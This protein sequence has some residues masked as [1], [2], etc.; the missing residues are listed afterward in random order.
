M[1]KIV[2]YVFMLAMAATMVAGVGCAAMSDYLTPATLDPQAVD[3]VVEAGVADANDYAGYANLYKARM[4]EI[5]MKGAHEW[6]VLYY[7]QLLDKENLSFGILNGVVERNRLEATALEK[8]IFDPTT[9]LLAA[10]L[11]LFGLAGGGVLGLM[12]TKPGDWKPADVEDALTDLTVQIGDKE[13]QFIETVKGIQAF[14]DD[15]GRE[16]GDSDLT[17][18][19]AVEGLKGWLADAQSTD[20]KKAVAVAKTA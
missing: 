12:R 7:A 11:G 8:S 14:I 13:R 18:L 2:Y 19:E 9:G 1:K 16:D 17:L 5:D 10:G 15:A 4:L 3:Y 20:T 6:N